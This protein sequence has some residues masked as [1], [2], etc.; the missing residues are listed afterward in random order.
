M[1]YGWVILAACSVA[2][3]ATAPGQT[4]VLSM[5]HAP[6]REATGLGATGLSG[7]YLVATLSSA[8][9]M[10]W[11]GR[12]SD[13]IGP[14]GVVAGAAFGLGLVCTLIGNVGGLFT[15]TLAFFGLRFFGQGALMLGSA[16]LLALWFERRLGTAEGIRGAVLAIGFAAMPPLVL[17]LIAWLGW[18]AAYA[19]LGVAVWV[20]VLP[21]ALFVIRDRPELLGLQLDGDPPVDD[22]PPAEPSASYTLD[23]SVRMAPFWSVVGLLVA[24]VLVVTAVI[25]HLQPLI[26]AAGM[27]PEIAG[28]AL[29]ISAFGTGMS[30]LAGGW[31]ADRADLR[32]LLL[33]GGVGCGVGTAL[34]SA[35]TTPGSALAVM[36]LLGVG[37]GLVMTVGVTAIARWFG[38][39]HHGSIRGFSS[40]LMIAGTSAGPLLLSGSRD[41]L[42]SWSPAL[43][44]LGALLAVLAGV[45]AVVRPPDA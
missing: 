34:L 17:A 9:T 23:E 24:T 43:L 1:Y 35:I 44:G 30:T 31:L 36:G 45:C 5:F 20:A 4:L 16:H 7:A 10:T 29:T 21:L 22:Q 19:S 13:R 8:L 11:V 28:Y 33:L 6:L 25:F 40:S 38:R 37:Q 15:L 2:A 42:G 3:I 14:R 32:R 39:R 18:A 27:A 41:L 12:L 26:E